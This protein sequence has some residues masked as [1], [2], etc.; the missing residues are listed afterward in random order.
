EGVIEVGRLVGNAPALL[1]RGA[2][3]LDQLDEVTRDGLTLSPQTIA[4]I[5]KA[6]GRRSR[7]T[8]AALWVIAALLFW[9]AARHWW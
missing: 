6:E 5:D 7:W 3:V 4:E 2:R 8:T 9:I 1:T